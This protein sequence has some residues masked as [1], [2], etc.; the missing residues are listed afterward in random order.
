MAE[1]FTFRPTARPVDTVAVN[2]NFRRL[3]TP[4]APVRPMAPIEPARPR[5]PTPSN[6]DQLVNALSALNPKITAA[7]GKFFDEENKQDA[8][9][10]EMR[11]LMD[12]VNSWGEA[13]AKDPTLA[14]RSPVFRQVYEARTARNRVQA[15][16]GQLISEYWQSDI[17]SSEDPTAINKWLSERMKDVLDTAQSPAER[18]AMAEEVMTVTRQFVQGHR[19]RARG[20]LVEK[21]RES[22]SVGFQT[23]I[24]NYAARGPAAP[25]QTDDPAVLEKLKSS[26]DPHAARKLAFL[27]AIAG[28]ESAGKYNIRY[29]GGAGS[30]FELNGRHPQ[31]K[32]QTPY[33]P[34]DAA[35]R[36]QFLS[37]TWRRVTG[38][39]AFTP[40]NQDLAAIRL[41]ELD[42][43]SRTGGR[44]L[45]QDMEK[46]GFSTRIQAALSPTWKALEGN[47]GRHIATFNASLQ[48]YGGKPTGDGVQNGYIPEMIE[49]L[50]K[51]EIEAKKQGMSPAEVSA[52]SVK[53]VTEA[54]VRQGDEAILDVLLK[55]R[56]DGT[57]GAGMTVAGRDAIDKARL[58]I[59]RLRIQEQNQQHT[60]EQRRK[61]VRK[62]EVKKAAIDALIGQQKAEEDAR[63]KGEIYNGPRGIPREIIE[64]ANREDPELAETLIQAQK[65][66]DDFNKRE[67]PVMIADFQRRV[68][69]GEAT[70]SDVFDAIARGVIKDPGTIRNLYDQAN[71]NI[72]R[73]VVTKPVVKPFYDMI[74]KII[75]EE[76][77]PGV[78]QKPLEGNA[79]T[80]AFSQALMEFENK[81]PNATDADLL[82]F[83]DET[84]KGL[85]KVYKP[86]LDLEAAK[87]ENQDQRREEEA[88]RRADAAAATSTG[89]QPAGKAA[90]SVKEAPAYVPLDPTPGVDWRNT[91]LF[92]DVQTLDRELARFKAGDNAG[93]SFTAWAVKLG[94]PQADF[95]EFLARQRTLAE[96]G[97]KGKQ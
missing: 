87:P 18:A 62:T 9:D 72:N 76:T 93:N 78:L 14:D 70:P 1:Q 91:Q 45:W 79:A 42:Y 16:A 46:E 65:T 19:E 36:Y 12:G 15:R 26:G 38:D 30:L 60:L 6:V 22:V 29:D 54:A 17:A 73:S 82:R 56:P 7:L 86:H 43:A 5:A 4:V 31:V 74:G 52:L 64:T 67:D 88:K 28:G 44:N 37:S 94:I 53:A 75:G 50:Q 3:P 92:P 97:S 10:A 2:T 57:P 89:K 61:E 83:A 90:K 69:N 41:A 40:E 34:S 32:V 11:V 81:N 25:Y 59:R 27:N 47:R 80:V 68:Y 71:R 95:G 85:V 24:D 13:V 39:A 33:G 20:N 58:E 23:T 96:R 21:N 66:M 49:E 48:K 77:L 63:A 84:Y 35:G 8:A 55:P 51:Q